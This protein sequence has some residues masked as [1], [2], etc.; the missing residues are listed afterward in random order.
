[1]KGGTTDGML[2]GTDHLLP[3]VGLHPAAEGVL[4]LG[5][6]GH[7]GSVD[8]VA[9]GGRAAAARGGCG[10]GDCGGGGASSCR[11]MPRLTATARA[12]V[13]GEDRHRRAAPR[14]ERV[15][16]PGRPAATDFF[17]FVIAK[18]EEIEMIPL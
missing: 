11:P 8:A 3:I 9:R 16:W 4:L 7:S 12:R 17:R 14:S 2:K 10:G 1:M 15:K 18:A 5:T 13:G 6:R